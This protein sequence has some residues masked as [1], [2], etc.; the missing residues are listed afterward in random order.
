MVIEE[1]QNTPRV[2]NQTTQ[3]SDDGRDSPD[4]NK[5][6]FAKHR[7]EPVYQKLKSYK[8]LDISKK[9]YR[10]KGL[11]TKT[12]GISAYAGSASL[13]S[14]VVDNQE[15]ISPQEQLMLPPTTDQTTAAILNK[16]YKA[17][18]VQTRANG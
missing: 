4:V 10:G 15:S 9:A 6:I 14:E 2:K 13:L 7:Y 5:L 1:E 8:V 12:T 16:D 3:R 18:K 11:D 17:L